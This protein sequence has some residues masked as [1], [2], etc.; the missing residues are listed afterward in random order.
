MTLIEAHHCKPDVRV[1]RVMSVSQHGAG[2]TRASSD[3]PT[4][5]H[6]HGPNEYL[7][8]GVASLVNVCFTF[9]LNK[10]MFR[11]QVHG[12]RFPKAFRQLYREGGLYV[13]RG[14]LPPLLQRTTTVSLMFGTYS[15]CKHSIEA[16]FPEMPLLGVHIV[17]SLGAG[18]I[19]AILTPFERVQVALQVTK[20]HNWLQNSFHASRVISG[21]GV[22]E[23]YRGASAVLMRNGPSNIVFLGLREPLQKLL[24]KPT[25]EIGKTINAFLSGAGLGATLST[26]FFPLNVVKTRMMVRVGG[27]FPGIIETFDLI[28]MERGYRWQAMFRGVHLNYTR[29][30]VS[31]GIINAVYELLRKHF[32]WEWYHERL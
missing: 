8:G 15:N 20:Y 3:P 13:F 18:T 29:S 4:R 27:H 22:R 7:C 12:I 31:W 24:P 19:E 14:L 17:A 21:Y 32:P 6:K 26:A 2:S 30:F 11:Q 23:L 9:P 5:P 1:C 16:H 28:Y 10:I 25:T